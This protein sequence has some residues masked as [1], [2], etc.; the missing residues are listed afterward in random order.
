MF[1]NLIRSWFYSEPV[2]L[3]SDFTSTSQFF[4]ALVKAVSKEGLFCGIS[5]SPLR[6]LEDLE[7]AFSP[8]PHGLGSNKTL[9]S[10]ALVNS[11]SVG[12]SSDEKQISL[13]IFQTGCFVLSPSRNTM[14][15][16]TF[17]IAVRTWLGSWK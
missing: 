13:G 10:L 16:L 12:K 11:F 7:L 2:P 14:A 6:R 3:G 1:C 8:P 5:F 15:Y 4:H 17:I 9:L